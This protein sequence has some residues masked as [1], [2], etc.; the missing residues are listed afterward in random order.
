MI[1]LSVSS[2]TCLPIFIEIGP[3]STEAEQKK[4]ARFFETQCIFDVTDN[5]SNP[6]AD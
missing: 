1:S 3:Y 6:T 2:R 5:D 4:L